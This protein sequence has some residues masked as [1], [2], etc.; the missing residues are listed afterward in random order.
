[1]RHSERAKRSCHSERAKRSCHSERAQRVEESQIVPVEG[2]RHSERAQRVE[3]SRVVNC[4]ALLVRDTTRLLDSE[5]SALPTAT[6]TVAARRVTGSASPPISHATP[7]SS[8]SISETFFRRVQFLICFSRAMASRGCGIDVNQSIYSIPPSEARLRTGAM[9]GKS[10]C[11][12][13]GNP[14]IQRSRPTREYVHIVRARHV[15]IIAFPARRTSSI[16]R[17]PN[18]VIPSGARAQRRR[19][20]GTSRRPDRDCSIGTA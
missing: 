6:T 4:K 12:I 11:E 3:E 8:A 17:G 5:P 19:S 10:F 20:R 14:D 1:M 2:P 13:V 9:L 15:A 18:R 16:G 7:D